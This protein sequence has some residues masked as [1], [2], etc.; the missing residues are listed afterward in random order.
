MNATQNIP[1]SDSGHLL[2]HE[3]NRRIASQARSEFLYEGMVY[4]C[5]SIRRV[6]VK[7]RGALPNVARRPVREA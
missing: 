3:T 6:L 4:I 7:N 5:H 1:V 2:S